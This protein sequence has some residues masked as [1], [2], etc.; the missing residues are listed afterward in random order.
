M[1][2]HFIAMSLS[3]SPREYS[4]RLFQN[5]ESDNSFTDGMGQ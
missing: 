1:V 5:L 3:I 4:Q 2:C